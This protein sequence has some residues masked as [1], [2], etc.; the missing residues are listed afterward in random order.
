MWQ[1]D[2]GPS[3]QA[4]G[5]KS[6]LRRRPAEAGGEDGGAGRGRCRPSLEGAGAGEGA[7]PFPA[8]GLGCLAAHGDNV[9]A[10]VCTLRKESEEAEWGCSGAS[11]GCWPEESP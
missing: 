6:Q 4:R 3:G 8:Q 10:S 2:R 11:E 5:E 7:C 9:L 1:V